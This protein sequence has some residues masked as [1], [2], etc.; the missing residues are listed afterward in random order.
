M[1]DSEKPTT[2]GAIVERK[3]KSPT[4]SKSSPG[5]YAADTVTNGIGYKP[6]S[7][8]RSSPIK[9]HLHLSAN[10]QHIDPPLPS[11]YSVS[12][13]S[14]MQPDLEAGLTSNGLSHTIAKQSHSN[15][16]PQRQTPSPML[17]EILDDD[18]EIHEAHETGII[19]VIHTIPASSNGS[20][21][22]VDTTVAPSTPVREPSASSSATATPSSN[23]KMTVDT[24]TAEL[25]MWPTQTDLKAKA[26]AEK[27]LRTRNPMIRLSKRNRIIVSIIIALT[28][29]GAAIGI[30]VG[31][32][33]A[34]HG[35]VWAGNGKQIPIGDG[36]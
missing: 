20:P 18:D 4:I 25:T 3:P 13:S 11:P 35:E 27:R 36:N 21:N 30:G 9:P 26:K 16:T 5:F 28:V 10:T 34:Y 7:V 29:I 19:P 2:F 32:S 17:G 33:R 31:V 12:E 22:M 24:R 1:M 15:H 14:N 23:E 8:D 6:D